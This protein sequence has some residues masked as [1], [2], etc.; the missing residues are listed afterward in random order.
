VS[1]VPVGSNDEVLL[2]DEEGTGYTIGNI[3]SATLTVTGD[4]ETPTTEEPTTE[5]PTT[6][7]PTTEEPTTEEPTTEEPTTEEPTT[8][9]PTTEEPTTEEPTTEEPTTEEPTTEEPTT[10]EP[11][12]EEPTT[13]EPTTEEPTTEEPTTEEPTTEEPTTDAPDDDDAKDCP[14]HDD[15]H[16]HAADGHNHPVVKFPSEQKAVVKN[17]GASK[18]HGYIEATY[19]YDGQKHS[20]KVSVGELDPGETVH[21]NGVTFERTDS[22]VHISVEDSKTIHGVEGKV[23]VHGGEFAAE[24]GYCEGNGHADDGH[25]HDHADDGHDHDHDHD[26]ADDGHD[27]AADGHNHPVVKFPSEQKAVVKNVGASKHH[28]YIEATYC[29]DGQKHSEKV[30]VGALD[31]GETAHANGITFERTDSAVHVSVEDSKTLHGVEGKVNVHGGEFA[32]ESGYCEGDHH[33]HE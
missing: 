32:A 10:E 6:E 11:T 15:D 2:F 16:D 4:G 26:H 29:Y 8:E 22:A 20:E 23:N 25:D 33:D 9:E 19:C 14:T 3:G 27:H 18:H 12:T 30:S 31:P 24:S 17:V 28:G 21:V 1:V 5:E 13:E 7:E